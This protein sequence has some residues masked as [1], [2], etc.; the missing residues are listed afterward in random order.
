MK[1]GERGKQR[2]SEGIAEWSGVGG[3]LHSPPRSGT[4]RRAAKVGVAVS[5]R[6][7]RFFRPFCLQPPTYRNAEHATERT[8]RNGERKPDYT[9]IIS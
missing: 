4:S 6:G 2:T 8:D 3:L 1:E 9:N 7:G 5:R